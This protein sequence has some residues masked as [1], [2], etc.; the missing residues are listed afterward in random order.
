MIKIQPHSVVDYHLR[1]WA[2]GPRFEQKLKFLIRAKLHFDENPG[3][4]ILTKAS[5]KNNFFPGLSD[6][7]QRKAKPSWD[8]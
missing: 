4:A 7:S 5:R 3:G 6:E 8:Y 2:E 1:F